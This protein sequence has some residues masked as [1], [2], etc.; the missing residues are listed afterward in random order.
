M[1]KSICLIAACF[2]V[3]SS[4]AG[5][6]NSSRTVAVVL[7][8]PRQHIPDLSLVERV[9]QLLAKRSDIKVIVPGEDTLMVPPPDDRLDVSRLS[10]WGK[11]MGCQYIV[12]LRVDSREVATRKQISIP[13]FLSRYKIEGRLEGS[14]GVIDVNRGKLFGPWDLRTR[15]NGP[16]QWQVG[17][18]YPDDPEL[19]MAAPARVRFIRE[20]EEKAADKIAVEAKSHMRGR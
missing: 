18:N 5:A 14:Y 15:V 9:N 1:S 10:A 4:V 8:K 19:L 11:Q 2:L 13:F 7:E 17:E 12:Y 16:K 6:Q 20:L 3:I